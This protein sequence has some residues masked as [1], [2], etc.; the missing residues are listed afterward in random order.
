[1]RTVATAQYAMSLCSFAHHWVLFGCYNIEPGVNLEH[2]GGNLDSAV[3][4]G[5]IAIDLSFMDTT[6]SDY[7]PSL[8][9]LLS[10]LATQ[11]L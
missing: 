1:M 10:A 7:K 9:L 8:F 2:I 5:N 4:S 6:F 11:Q 3:T